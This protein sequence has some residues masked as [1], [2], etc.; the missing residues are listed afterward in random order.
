MNPERQ[1]PSRSG[2]HSIIFLGWGSAMCLLVDSPT[3]SPSVRMEHN[4]PYDAS[5]V[6][7]EKVST[8]ERSGQG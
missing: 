2:S 7:S 8:L 6:W 1:R 3:G 4:L 5:M